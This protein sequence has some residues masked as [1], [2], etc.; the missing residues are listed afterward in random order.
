M[1]GPDSEASVRI[2]FEPDGNTVRVQPGVSLS[3]AAVRAGNMMRFECGGNGKCGKCRMIVKDQGPLTEI[4][5]HER[6]HLSPSEIEAGYRLACQAHVNKDVVVYIPPESRVE[7]RKL[8]VTGHETPITID[9]YV[10]K[11][12][13]VL[14]KPTLDDSKP[15][16]ERLA[17]IL[18]EEHGVGA[19]EIEQALLQQLP[20]V[21]REAEWDIT[22]AVWEGDKII[23]VEPGDTTGIMYG[24]AVD[25]GT[26][27]MVVHLVDLLTGETHGVGSVENPQIMRGE[28]LLTRVSYTMTE[29]GGLAE[30]QSQAVSGVNTALRAACREAAVDPSHIYEAT[31]V[32]NTVMHHFLLAIEPRYLSLSPFTPALKGPINVR[33][34]DLGFQMNPHGVVIMMP[35]VAGF[36]GSDAV[37]DVLSSGVYEGR[38][39]SLLLDIGTNTEIFLGNDEGLICCSCASG[40]AFEGGHI[41]HGMKA[42][43]GAIENVSLNPSTHRADFSTI[44]GGRPRGLCGSAMI[45]IVAELRRNGVIDSTGKFVSGHDSPSLKMG[46]GKPV[47]V[48]VNEEDSATGQEIVVTQRDI[49]EIQRAKAAIY[50]GCSILMRRRNLREGDISRILI[51]GAFGRSLN[52]ENARLLGLVP[53]LPAEKI[54][55][56]GNTAVTGA[57]M[58][59]LSK[60]AR[61]QANVISDKVKYLELS[62]D[63][64]FG[65]EFAMALFI[66][67]RDSTR[68]QSLSLSS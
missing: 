46:E 43:T 50:S 20:R 49:N 38:E 61:E 26:S 60:K 34:R 29:V 30:L 68:F 44:G 4:T 59:L 11:F 22:V 2:V 55:L 67:H 58:A 32:G 6:R 5:I 35:L 52:P 48:L 41:R 47:F 13:V 39:A 18:Q 62:S 14:P 23:A 40:P 54:R 24:V 17:S 21:L 57:K 56:L 8:Q 9:P 25:V 15:D 64:L 53:D 36:V 12:H 31:V 65:S 33:A 66:P 19:L 37:A 10:D 3:K 1:H 63:P 45:D 28:D 27:K 16:L 7:R 51:S 42:V